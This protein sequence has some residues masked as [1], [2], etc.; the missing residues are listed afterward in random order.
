MI[1]HV[2]NDYKLATDIGY[3]DKDGFWVNVYHMGEIPSKEKD[4]KKDNFNYQNMNDK[5][6]AKSR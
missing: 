2:D 4:K 5:Y 1:A 3:Y 6:G